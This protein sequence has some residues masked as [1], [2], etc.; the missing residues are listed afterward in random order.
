[1]KTITVKIP[2]WAQKAL[3][4]KKPY[5]DSGAYEI[6]WQTTVKVD[7]YEID[8]MLQNTPSGA[9]LNMP[10]FDMTTGVGFEVTCPE[11]GYSINSTVEYFVDNK[12]Y[13]LKLEQE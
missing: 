5:P 7:N 4:M 11:P 6:L 2:K 1:M 8:I 13:C 10:M 9:Y 12:E 3:K